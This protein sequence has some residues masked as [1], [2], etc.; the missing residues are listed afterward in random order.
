MKTKR[1]GVCVQTAD[2]TSYKKMPFDG[3]QTVAPHELHLYD[4]LRSQIPIIDASIDKI[5]RL[6]GTFNVVCKQSKSQDALFWFLNQVKVGA[7]G[8]G[9]QSFLNTYLQNLLTYG[10][11]I[12]E[13]VLNTEQTAIY[14]LYNAPIKTVFVKQ[15]QSALDIDFYTGD[16][17]EKQKVLFPE[18]ILF[19]TI[20]CESGEIVGK[21]ILSGLAFV[22]SILMKILGSI[23]TN[24]ERIANLRYAVTYKPPEGVLDHAQASQIANSIAKEWSTAMNSSKYGVVKDFIA[25]GDVGI[26]VIGAENKMIDTEIPVRQMLEQIIAKLGIPPFML[27]LSWSTSERMSKQQSDILTSELESY[28]LKLEPIITKICSVFLRLKG[29]DDTFSI[30]W[31]HINLQDEVEIAKANLLIAQSNQI[32][33]KGE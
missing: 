4:E 19:S 31:N 16:A 30:E 13:I 28:R 29:L 18:R 7:N 25:V 1:N 14:G 11:A 12:G 10:N 21:S 6:I 17:L 27:G 22:S 20:H 24:F 33:Q 8:T 26:Q 15:G 2:N 23:G 32:G 5:V 3:L 9:I